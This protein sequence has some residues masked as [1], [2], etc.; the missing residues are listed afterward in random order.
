MI[1]HDPGL[2]LLMLIKKASR[3]T[4]ELAI[5]HELGEGSSVCYRR[6]ESAIREACLMIICQVARREK[7]LYQWDTEHLG[8]GTETYKSFYNAGSEELSQSRASV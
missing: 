7:R 2:C 8:M 4:R 5:M 1:S 3:N 6:T